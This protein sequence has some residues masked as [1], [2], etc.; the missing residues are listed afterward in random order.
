MVKSAA[1]IRRMEQRAVARGEEF[2]YTPPEPK[3]DAATGEVSTKEQSTNE[4]PETSKILEIGRKL[5]KELQEIEDNAELKAKDRRSMKRKAEVIAS[6]EAGMTASELVEFCEKNA[7]NAPNTTDNA[8]TAMLEK[9]VKKLQ[10]EVKKIE[11]SEELKAK[12]RRSAKN[13]AKAIASEESGMPAAELLEWYAQHIKSNP[14]KEKKNEKRKHDP[15]VAFVGQLSYETTKDEL[16]QHIQTQLKDEF[17]IKQ[18]TLSIRMLTDEKTK[19]SRGMAFVEVHDDPEILYGL[20]KLHQTFLKGRRINIERSAGGKKNN[21]SRKSKINQFRKEQKE[22]FDEVVDNILNE[23]KKTGELREDELDAGVIALCKRH[24]GPIVRAAV[25]KYIEGS[26][27][28]MDNPS[29]Y[30]S[31]LITKFAEEGLYEEKEGEKRE[32]HNQKPKRKHDEKRGGENEASGRA[33][34]QFKSSSKFSKSGIDMSL[35]QSKGDV[36]KIFP[37]AGRGRGRGYM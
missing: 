12:D 9:V 29:A 4:S 35:S 3:P 24:A 23:Y 25:S 37:S 16:F 5:K 31:F 17:K 26:G 7:T 33:S 21:E 20:L 22:Y 8:K 6:E 28:D 30:L 1:Q 10:A 32:K 14:G 19:K 15:Y 27:R 18:S 13:K 36:T 2:I 34:K 11:E